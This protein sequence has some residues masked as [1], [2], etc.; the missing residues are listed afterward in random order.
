[1]ADERDKKHV[2]VVKGSGPGQTLRDGDDIPRLDADAPSLP[3]ASP[4]PLTLEAVS[5]MLK[6]ITRENP[7]TWNAYGPK[8]EGEPSIVSLRDDLGNPAPLVTPSSDVADIYV[9]G[10][11]LAELDIVGRT[12]DDETIRAIRDPNVGTHELLRTIVANPSNSF[13]KRDGTKISTGGAATSEVPP[14]ASWMQRKI[15]TVLQRNRFN[16][17]PGKTPFIEMGTTSSTI[18]QRSIGTGQSHLGAHDDGDANVTYE[19]MKRVGLALMLRAT[20]EFIGKDGDPT[21][22]AAGAGALVPGQAQ[23]AAGRVDRTSM[24]ASSLS[25]EQGRPRGIRDG[26]KT[27]SDIALDSGEGSYGNLNSFL[28]PF[29]GFAPVGMV[30]LG[31]ALVVALRVVLEGLTFLMNP[32]MPPIGPG[33]N[34]LPLPG[35]DR[36]PRTMGHSRRVGEGERFAASAF[37]VTATRHDFDAAF[38]KGI[39]A[40]FG[41]DGTDFLRVVTSPGYYAVLVR[42]IVRS[43]ATAIQAITDAFS[44]NPNPISALQALLGIVDILRGSKL[45]GFINMTTMIGD[46]LLTLEELGMAPSSGPIPANASFIDQLRYNPASRVMKSRIDAS[47]STLAWAGATTPSLYVLPDS[48]VNAAGTFP[49]LA[50]T[51]RRSQDD[52]GRLTDEAGGRL[53]QEVVKSVEDALD[54]EYVP[55]YFHDLRTNEI[56][57]FHA[58]LSAVSD[59][60]SA[61]YSKDKYYGR[62]DPVSIYGDTERSIGITFNIVSTNEED[63]DVMWW[64]INKLVTLLYPQWSK[65]RRLEVGDNA[66]I[67][68]FS[69]VP[70]SSPV[71]RLRLGDVF[72]SNYSKFAL[73]RLFGLGTEGFLGL[74][75]QA[76]RQRKRLEKFNEILRARQNDPAFHHPGD[77]YPE[78][79]TAILKPVEMLA[80]VLTEGRRLKTTTHELVKILKR[81]VGLRDRFGTQYEIEFVE[82]M[83]GVE[84][85]PYVVVHDDLMPDPEAIKALVNEEADENETKTV[86]EFFKSDADPETSNAVVRSFESVRGRGLAGVITSMDFDWQAPR[87]E[88]TIGRR[89]PQYCTVSLTFDPM[90]DIAPGLDADGFNR[91]PI[92]NVG[93]QVRSVGRD[94]YDD[95]KSDELYRDTHR[96]VLSNLKKR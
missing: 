34:S 70:T 28:E 50:G 95:G 14:D 83:D 37:G 77:G 56:I 17:T 10:E 15:S 87:W 51:V 7:A 38:D 84:P 93:E 96:R 67:Q 18:D 20:G 12:F 71:I 79:E 41:F 2:V 39:D 92:Y 82:P 80:S 85:G 75:T 89:A 8:F 55:F 62:V 40:F 26:F 33:A 76:Q 90:H 63:F 36:T 91:A 31:A 44:K 73:A 5:R 49:G 16:P 27:D 66:F 52:I 9:L 58:F 3:D 25:E 11:I 35:Q 94:P 68:P 78:S 6:H 61:T 54:S 48:I 69:Q 64:K 29:A 72:R 59:K 21:S 4:A 42:S 86:A 74:G 81:T 60:F 23:L 19:Q 1:M 45:I 22:F 57:S 53:S 47:R 65:G 32:P 46:Q 88:T 24:Y 13:T 30:A 43:S